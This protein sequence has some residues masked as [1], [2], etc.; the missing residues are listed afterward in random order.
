MLWKPDGDNW[1]CYLHICWEDEPS[2]R[3]LQSFL[4]LGPTILSRKT[5]DR[6]LKSYRLL[7]IRLYLI[8]TVVMYFNNP[9]VDRYLS[10]LTSFSGSF[11]HQELQGS[12]PPSTQRTSC[13]GPIRTVDVEAT[14]PMAVR[15]GLDSEWTERGFPLPVLSKHEQDINFLFHISILAQLIKNMLNNNHCCSVYMFSLSK[16]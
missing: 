10:V 1:H 7:C 2:R 3:R 5:K 8:T 9:T 4:Q 14:G 6:L 13:S 16:N 12:L 15:G 11:Q